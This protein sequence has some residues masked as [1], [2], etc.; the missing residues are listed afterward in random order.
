MGESTWATCTRLE[1]EGAHKCKKRRLRARQVVEQLERDSAVGRN[2]VVGEPV[3]MLT[4]VMHLAIPTSTFPSRTAPVR[5]L[6]TWGT[7]R[8]SEMSAPFNWLSRLP[9][10][11]V[12]CVQVVSNRS[13]ETWYGP[14]LMF[15]ARPARTVAESSAAHQV[16]AFRDVRRKLEQ[17]R[18]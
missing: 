5:V 9:S 2:E 14:P 4:L 8:R 3:L 16:D 10:D 15:D 17:N 1:P 13:I 6:P 18:G 12:H 11:V 7:T